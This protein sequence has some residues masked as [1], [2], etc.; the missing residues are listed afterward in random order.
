MSL[1][2]GS[3]LLLSGCANKEM[4]KSAQ[5]SNFLGSYNDLKEDKN[6]DGVA[7]WIAPDANFGQYD[8]IMIAP[9]QINH[10]LTEA[11][12]TPERIALFKEMSAYLTEGIMAGFEKSQKL[13]VVSSAGPNTLKL[14]TSMSGVAVNY[15]DMKFYQ[16]T[17]VTLA[18]T[19]IARATVSNAAVRVLGEAKLTDSQSNKV[20]FRSMGLQK[21]QEIKSSKAQLTFADVKP[22]L[23]QWLANSTQRTKEIMK[24]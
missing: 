13:K 16:F 21:G 9:V 7:S 20:L 14:E 10:G 1:A 19:A 4:L 12:L 6:Y 11:E 24:K 5:K 23:D 8:S 17:P 18:I 2:L 15:D 22:A 3:L